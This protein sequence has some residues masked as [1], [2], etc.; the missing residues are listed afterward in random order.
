[1][2]EL[3][4]EFLEE[5]AEVM[6]RIYSSIDDDP[7][8]NAW[9][10]PERRKLRGWILHCRAEESFRRIATTFSDHFKVK[11]VTAKNGFPHT[12]VNCGGFHMTLGR[13]D[14]ARSV[15]READYRK[16]YASQS[17]LQFTDPIFSPGEAP[18]E[19]SEQSQY[20]FIGHGPSA[21][22]NRKLGFLVAQFVGRDGM[23][24]IGSGIDL[25]QFALGEH[26]PPETIEW[27]PPVK[28]RTNSDPAIFAEDQA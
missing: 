1:M 8:L 15:P 17:Q 2:A 19:I 7:Y 10:M 9:E 28:K 25:A 21:D 12:I 3:P 27:I 14:D 24:Y 26:Y 18:L 22:D 6:G 23:N 16:E 11:V 5:L 13:L 20:V 4:P